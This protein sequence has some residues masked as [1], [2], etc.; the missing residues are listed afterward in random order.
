M[1]DKRVT[2]HTDSPAPQRLLLATDLCTRCDR[3]LD[4]AKQLAAEWQASLT[5]VMVRDGPGTP[6]EVS[7]W[8]DGSD[9]VHA[10]EQAARNEVAAEFAGTGVAATL[11]V[12]RGDVTDGIVQAATA[13]TDPVVII[14][15]SR[16]GG[17]QQLFLGST[18]TRLAQEL[19][20]PLLVVRQRTRGSYARI[21]VANDFGDAARRALDSAIALFPGRLITLMHVLEVSPA[22][23]PAAYAG[24]MH[25]AQLDSEGFLDRC[26]LPD[27]ARARIDIVIGHGDVP[28]AIA[29]YVAAAATELVVLGVHPISALARVFTGSYSDELLR[30]LP[31][32]T[33]LVRAASGSA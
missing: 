1:E 29:G 31:C 3:P 23:P 10:F 24:A 8:L 22:G 21:L 11:Q 13:L 20:Q 2:D 33:L 9:P 15:A 25:Q 30:R 7:S 18:A 12:V 32:D 6:E 4:R 14:G 26:A 19:A 17:F 27:D 28:D 5:I 16:D